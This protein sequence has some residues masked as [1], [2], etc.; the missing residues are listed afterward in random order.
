MKITSTTVTTSGNL[1][2]TEDV[3]MGF[4][5][6]ASAFLLNNLIKQYAN[7]YVA[8]LREYTSNA[9]DAHAKVKQT[10][11]VEVTLP[12]E[13]SPQLVIEDFG[14]G[15]TREEMKGYGQFGRSDK[16]DSNEYVGGFG[17]GSKSGLAVAPQFTVVSVKDGKRN[18][19]IVTRRETGQPVMRFLDEQD[20]QGVPNG[21]RITI[22]SVERF[23]FEEAIDNNF[24]LGWEPGTILIDGEEPEQE[25]TLFGGNFE[26]LG[27]L[28]W[29]WKPKAD[30]RYKH[31]RDYNL[32]DHSVM[33]VVAGV[34]FRLDLSQFE[35]LPQSLIQNFLSEI[36]IKLDNG[37]VTIHPS[38]ESLTYDKPTRDFVTKR[39]EDILALGREAYQDDI[40]AAKTMREVFVIAKKAY[41]FGFTDGFT[42]KKKP[43][44]DPEAPKYAEPMYGVPFTV[45]AIKDGGDRS[46]YANGRDVTAYWNILSYGF[47]EIYKS[48]SILVVESAAPDY[49]RNR[50]LHVES[51]G[52]LAYASWLAEQNKDPKGPMRYR[53]YYVSN[54]AKDFPAEF[55]GAFEKVVKAKDYMAVV[56]E[57]RKKAAQT[58]AANRKAN[59]A[60]N[61]QTRT[62]DPIR[63]I[64]YRAD[65]RSTIRPAIPASDLSAGLTYILLQN[66]AGGVAETVR[67][68]LVSTRAHQQNRSLSAMVNYLVNHKNAV[69]VVANKNEKV[70][71]YTKAIPGLVTDIKGLLEDIAKGVVA[72]KSEYQRL[73]HH[74]IGNDNGRTWATRIPAS[75]TEKIERK[76]TRKWI[77]AM[78]E[79]SNDAERSFLASYD[80]LANSWEN[81]SLGLDKTVTAV[82]KSKFSSPSKRY[83]LL[84]SMELYRT[85]WKDVVEYINL[86]DAQ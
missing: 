49:V 67:N 20:V 54:K 60:A 22:P 81:S 18:T 73:A 33:A 41:D 24:F 16:R 66:G 62:K 3:D 78:Q 70:E 61:P 86:K 53:T 57:Q 51:N 80:K 19:V 8:T 39:I 77:E 11:P 38:R 37:S 85:E 65:G 59:A 56:T 64:A 31:K 7:P 50:K 79:T 69:F 14:P 23:K 76:G 1:T 6:S 48:H 27:G 68:I 47:T 25:T 15:L 83:P 71:K 5:P 75:F 74:D 30:A 12:N 26:D 2:G 42:W 40:D 84:K 29:R 36:V 34:Q 43:V 32:T 45:S 4:D 46:E 10:R 52:A 17:L 13:L 28:G 55:L 58:A 35:K 63:T 72:N 9:R 44:K 21:V 82:P